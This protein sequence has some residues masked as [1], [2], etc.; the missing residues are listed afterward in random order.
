[1]LNHFFICTGGVQWQT[2]S[3]RQYLQ[4]HLSYLNKS[5][6]RLKIIVIIHIHM[7]I[8]DCQVKAPYNAGWGYVRLFLYFCSPK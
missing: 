8:P 5:N 3:G 7:Q 2:Y 4:P 1:M 6:K